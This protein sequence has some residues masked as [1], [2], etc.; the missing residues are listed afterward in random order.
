MCVCVPIAHRLI[1]LATSAGQ[2]MGAFSS[3]GL[4][5]W[6][7]GAQ[8][9][10]TPRTIETAGWDCPCWPRGFSSY[11][12]LCGDVLLDK[13]ALRTGGGESTLYVQEL[14]AFSLVNVLELHQYPSST[15][16]RYA[17]HYTGL[18]SKDSL[19]FCT[20][21][22]GG[23]GGG[24]GGWMRRASSVGGG[25]RQTEK[26]IMEKKSRTIVWSGR[27]E[28]IYFRNLSVGVGTGNGDW[29]LITSVSRDSGWIQKARSARDEWQQP[30]ENIYILKLSFLYL[31]E[32]KRR[33]RKKQYCDREVVLIIILFII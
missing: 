20:R 5:I 8:G 16:E 15:F 29:E 10:S 26:R 30:E 27:I 31:K 14:R 6:P 19:F 12:T 2:A 1:Q 13:A 17:A 25:Q 33:K 23:G 3:R 18:A 4:A 24:G 22:T 21:G 9:V 28:R 32:K 7:N 11:E